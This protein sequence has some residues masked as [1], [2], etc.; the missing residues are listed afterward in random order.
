MDVETAKAIN[1]VSKRVTEIQQKM[2][3]FLLD[4]QEVT[5]NGLVDVAD[6][7]NAHDEAIADLAVAVSEIAEKEA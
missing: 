7:I 2:E 3:Q 4:R 1:D 5:N 6:I